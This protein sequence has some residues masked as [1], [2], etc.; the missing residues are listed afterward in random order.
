MSDIN[1]KEYCYIQFPLFLLRNMLI[2]KIGTI[3]SIFKYGIW[4]YSKKINYSIESTSRQL[5]YDYYRGFL[6]NNLKSKIDYYSETG[7]IT[8]DYDNNSFNG[9]E[10]NPDTENLIHILNNDNNFNKNAIQNYQLHLALESLKINFK[11]KSIIIQEAL[12]I[13]NLISER[14]PMPMIKV[15]LLFEYRD[16]QKSEFELIQL[17][18]YVALNS[19]IGKKIYCKTNC[20]HVLSRMRGYSS[21]KALPGELDPRLQTIFEK[22]NKRYHREKLFNKIQTDWKIHIYSNNMR[23]FYFAKHSNISLNELAEKAEKAKQCRKEKELKKRKK[24]AKRHV[25]NIF[26]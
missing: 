11:N 24:E 5:M 23:G 18:C 3:S 8:L 26:K 20:N 4:N 17:L 16:N 1:K 6:P 22:Y 15:K 12:R 7:A 21:I 2:D 9:T 14:E 25:A 10:F 19:I 13:S